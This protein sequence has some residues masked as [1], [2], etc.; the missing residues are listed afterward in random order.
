MSA[1]DRASERIVSLQSD[2]RVIAEATSPVIA[3]ATSPAPPTARADLDAAIALFERER[4]DD[5][6][7]ALDAIEPGNEPDPE[8]LLLRAVLLMQRGRFGEAEIACDELCHVDETRAG[9][10]YLLALCREAAG[11]VAEAAQHHRRAAEI[12]PTFAMPVL[13]L[14][15]I[16]RRTGNTAAARR[17]L[18]RALSIIPSE[19]AARLRLFGGGFSRDTLANLCRAELR[20]CGGES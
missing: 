6:L 9:A 18:E 16:E 2:A 8:R 7:T 15:T 10:H 13:H 19:D 17:L 20:S 4:Y 11:D 5:A 12:D 14:G 1:V 3:E